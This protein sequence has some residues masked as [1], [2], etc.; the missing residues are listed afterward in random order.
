[1]TV[2]ASELDR[3]PLV[4]GGLP[5]IGHG[6]ALMRNPLGLLSSLPE[7]G[8]MCRIRLG[9]DT[10]VFVSDP[11]LTSQIFVDD[12]AFDKGGPFYARAREIAG[13]GLGSCPH[14][15]HRR[16][17]RLCQPAFGSG[18]LVSYVSS[19]TGSIETTVRGWH[20]GQVIDLGVELS[21][22]TF[23]IATETMFSTSLSDNQTREFATD[24]SA[25][26][27]GLLRRTAMPAIINRLPTPDNRRY[28]AITR[29]VRQLAAS[30]I[31]ERR[32]DQKDR[33]DL[34][35]ALLEARDAQDGAQF[36]DSELIDQVFTF[37]LG[38]AETTAGCLTWALYLLDRNPDVQDAL[39]EEIDSV[40][41]GRAATREDLPSLP[42]TNRI[43]TETL[44][45]YPPTW[46]VTRQVTTD[47]KLGEILLPSGT[48]I[49]V[50]PYVIHR[51]DQLYEDPSAFRPNRWVDTTPHHHRKTFIPFGLGAR[52]C[53]GEQF[54]LIEA[55]LALATITGRWR[56]SSSTQRPISMSMTQVPVP[57]GVQMRVSTR[58]G[59]LVD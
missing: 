41:G 23:R 52:R 56:L 4:A 8:P 3:I 50:S 24:L 14:D 19:M 7:H 25:I 55:A 21:A 1:M 53:I 49:A 2:E 33:G 5:L 47:T 28:G 15:Q 18:R 31:A 35:S 11:E 42:L 45:L 34:L 22:M 43:I 16:Q 46:V 58:Q 9:T 40:L 13:D 10:V 17:R 36:T 20:D 32:A 27:H 38:G 6:L 54:G 59:A 39:H 44:R 12:K 30:V 57:D 29:R 51:S 37:F 26:A 48:S